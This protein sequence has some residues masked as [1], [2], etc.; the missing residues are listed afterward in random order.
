MSARIV[1][2]EESGFLLVRV[3]PTGVG[4]MACPSSDNPA[5]CEKIQLPDGTVGTAE[6]MPSNSDQR[7]TSVL[8]HRPDGPSVWLITNNYSL[9]IG[10]RSGPASRCTPDHPAEPIR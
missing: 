7:Q 5:D 9:A 8:L 4:E 1:R 3:M 10:P 2:G 6:E